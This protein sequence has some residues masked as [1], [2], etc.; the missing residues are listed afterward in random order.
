MGYTH[1]Y[2]GTREECEAQARASCVD[3]LGGEER[4]QKLCDD[5]RTEMQQVKKNVKTSTAQQYKLL[6]MY[7]PFAGIAGYWP[8]RAMA[9]DILKPCSTDHGVQGACAKCAL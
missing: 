2:I 1:H 3:W 4:Y 5:L 8:I 7:I 9:R 6:R